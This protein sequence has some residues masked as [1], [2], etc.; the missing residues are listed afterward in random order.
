MF[1]LNPGGAGA[2]GGSGNRSNS[3]L[4]GEQLWFFGQ[5]T[6]TFAAFHG[7]YLFFASRE[8]QQQIRSN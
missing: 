5:I 6:L 2:G 8:R 7:I 4:G 3:V 1:T